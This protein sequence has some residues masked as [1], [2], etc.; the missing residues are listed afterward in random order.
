MLAFVLSGAA[1]FGAMQAGALEII[2][3]STLQPRML[4]GTSAGALN[5]IFL[6]TEPSG[7]RARELQ[8][9]W[10]EAGPD[11]VGVP[12]PFIALRRL[13]QQKDG[14]IDGS[15]LAHFL[16]KR[17]PTEETFGELEKVG[18]IKTFAVAVDVD[19]GAMRVFG[20]DPSDRLLDGAMASS[21]VPPYFPPWI[22]GKQRYL[23]G[24]VFAKLPLCVAIERG[25]TQIIALDV[26]YA[27]GS[28]VNAHGVMGM[29]GYSLSLMIEAQTAF[30]V[31][32]ARMT[33]V[34][35]RRLTLEAPSDI[36]FWDYTKAD[37]LIA[38]GR[39]RAAAMLAE[40]PLRQY[41]AL[42]LS[43]R[44]LRGRAAPHPLSALAHLNTTVDVEAAKHHMER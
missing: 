40:K 1:N 28:S 37:L 44:K 20:D 38:L 8:E 24:G 7:A 9:M 36:P 6:A 17:L 41:S 30:E 26:T 10:R 14:L 43:W 31:A 33:G 3:E 18:G 13:V 11:Q 5:A 27:M 35:I 29:S 23:D 16:E 34:P 19:R 39:E 12:K 15:R 25:A 42:T 32:W 4:V 22:V 21:A 2:L